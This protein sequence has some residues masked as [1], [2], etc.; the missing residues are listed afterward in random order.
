[1]PTLFR[2]LDLVKQREVF[3]P[4]ITSTFALSHLI[5]PYLICHARFGTWFIFCYARCAE[6]IRRYFMGGSN[7]ATRLASRLG[8]CNKMCMF[9]LCVAKCIASNLLVPSPHISCISVI[10]ARNKFSDKII[11]LQST[12]YMAFQPWSQYYNLMLTKYKSGTQSHPFKGFTDLL[13]IML[14][15]FQQQREIIN[16]HLPNVLIR[17]HSFAIMGK[18][19]LN[20]VPF[21]SLPGPSGKSKEAL[22]SPQSNKESPLVFSSITKLMPT[23]S[24][25][26]FHLHMQPRQSLIFWRATLFL[27]IKNQLVEIPSHNQRER[28][29]I[30][31]TT[32]RFHEWHLFISGEK[33]KNRPTTKRQKKRQRD[34]QGDQQNKARCF[35]AS[36]D[37]NG[38]HKCQ[39]EQKRR[40]QYKVALSEN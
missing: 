17:I 23:L 27:I 8:L 13:H 1:M 16:H 19:T 24:L 14:S 38:W 37:K 15:G 34:Q 20:S 36:T 30:A 7:N 3:K 5:P 32:Q 11:L 21:L 12:H 40:L 2:K 29:Q 18:N 4:Q 9:Y 28:I 35:E 6:F 22:L 25:P 39:K 33:K 26:L 10:Y 31:K